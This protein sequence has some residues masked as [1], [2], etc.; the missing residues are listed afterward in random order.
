MPLDLEVNLGADYLDG[1]KNKV[2]IEHGDFV[3]K[4]GKFKMVPEKDLGRQVGQRLHVRLLLRKGEVFFNTNAGFPYLQLSKFKEKT[5]I[6]DSYM[7]RYISDT[8]GVTQLSRYNAEMSRGARKVSV[9]FE[10][11]T[12]ANTLVDT[13]KEIN[14]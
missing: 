3:I 14:V 5:N 4:D 8:V 13:V 12:S 10:V 9:D 6:F 1:E 2:L 11:L 7:K